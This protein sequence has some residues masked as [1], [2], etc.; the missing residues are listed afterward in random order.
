MDAGRTIRKLVHPA[1]R[2]TIILEEDR[3]PATALRRTG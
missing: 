1:I 3:S 2:G